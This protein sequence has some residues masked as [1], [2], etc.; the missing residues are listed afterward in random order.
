MKIVLIAP[1]VEWKRIFDEV[2]SLHNKDQSNLYE[3]LD[4]E[5]E[6]VVLDDYLNFEHFSIECDALISRGVA[7]TRLRQCMEIPVVQIPMSIFT[8]ER[9]ARQAVQLYNPKKVAAVGFFSSI[10]DTS[11]LSSVDGVPIE[12]YTISDG[13]ISNIYQECEYLISKALDNGC[14]AFI[15]GSGGIKICERIG[16]SGVFLN[17]NH[18]E[19]WFALTE[20]KHSACIYNQQRLQTELYKNVLNYSFEGIVSL[21]RNME[22]Q[23][24]NNAA[25]RMLAGERTEEKY[26]KRIL[27]K[28][29]C[30]SGMLKEAADRK[31]HIDDLVSFQEKSFSVSIIPTTIKGENFGSV[32]FLQEVTRIQNLESKIRNKNHFRGHEAKYRFCDILGISEKIRAVKELSVKYAEVDSNILIYGETGTGK[33]IFAQS[34][35]NQSDRCKGPF[36]AVNCAA[37]SENL[38]ESEL[39]G[40]VDG[41]F[42]GAA[43]SG[44][45]GFFELAH[46]GT[47]FLDEISEMP[48]SLQ[49]KLLR[50]LE[51]KQIVRLGDD[52]ITPVNVR[53]VSAT[54]RNLDRMVATG[55]FRED[56][57]Y[58]LNVLHLDLPPLAERLEDVPV[59]IKYFLE[60]YMLKNKKHLE[61]DEGAW[62]EL[63]YCEWRG[64]IRQLRNICERII[65]VCTSGS[66]TRH[67]VLRVVH[68]TFPKSCAENHCETNDD[69][70]KGLVDE[71][72]VFER[73]RLLQ[74]FQ[75]SEWN[76]EEVCRRL[77]I[78]RAT[79]YR[80][81]KK[82]RFR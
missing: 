81:M 55:N 57:Y 49:G 19:A 34:I 10:I 13:C 24:Y 80:K 78:S 39:F 58:R 30:D 38:L 20:A 27:T 64:N 47:I 5:L 72:L 21:D 82:F 53:I 40:Y 56:L 77:S 67:D 4:F 76:K 2:L 41:A 63:K 50:V 3:G 29:L 25:K 75:L 48:M 68:S 70:W 60:E 14:D 31:S 17:I 33:E 61:I 12:F 46:N 62:E 16:L 23:T 36:V 15:C 8:I 22:I 45:L 1:I 69:T 11:R 43:K 74:A 79:L 52:K 73:N 65:A 26:V 35:H 66:V 42:T 18:Q 9:A 7:T 59:L 28:Y 51:E 44:K 32:V 37:L 71:A 6:T 54:N